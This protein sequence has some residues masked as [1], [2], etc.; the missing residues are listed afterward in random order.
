MEQ[1]KK[2]DERLELSTLGLK[3]PHANQSWKLGFEKH[4]RNIFAL[5]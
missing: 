5:F 2:L 1:Q 4:F 3:G